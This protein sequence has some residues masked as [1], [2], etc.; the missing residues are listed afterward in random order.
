MGGKKAL[1]ATTF[2]LEMLSFNVIKLGSCDCADITLEF[3]ILWLFIA[4]GLG[5]ITFFYKDFDNANFLG[6]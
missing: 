5:G 4:L 6:E 3:F 2:D 1:P